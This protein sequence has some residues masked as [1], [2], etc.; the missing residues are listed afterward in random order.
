M[1]MESLV[2]GTQRFKYFKRPIMPR[3]NAYAP[4]VLLAPT[5]GSNDSA[6]GSGALNNPLQ[7]TF[8][9]TE[10]THKDAGMQ[11][12]FRD[13]EAQT[14]PYTPAYIVPA[15]QEPEILLFK[16]LTYESGLPMGPREMEMV[17]YTR[18][19]KDMEG[20]RSSLSTTSPL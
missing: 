19:K 12:V 13:S 3:V 20:E 5:G 17:E 4:E 15:G 2:S 18:A 10:T 1:Q 11:T 16:K 9:P 7:P 8:V 6:G 14:N